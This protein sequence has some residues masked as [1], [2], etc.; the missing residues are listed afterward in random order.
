MSTTLDDLVVSSSKSLS[1]T[2]VSAMVDIDTTGT[3]SSLLLDVLCGFMDLPG[4]FFSNRGT[5]GQGGGRV[6]D[7]SSSIVLQE[8]SYLLEYV[9]DLGE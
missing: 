6:D 2:C 4:E 7:F 5:S 1:F 9:T 8:S 3:C